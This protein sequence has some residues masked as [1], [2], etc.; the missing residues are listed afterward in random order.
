MSEPIQLGI[1]GWPVA[2]SKSPVMHESAARALGISLTYEK[3][4][5]E[6]DDLVEE[7]HFKPAQATHSRQIVARDM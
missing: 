5:V 1:F 2:H 6:P 7:I 3:F 4:A